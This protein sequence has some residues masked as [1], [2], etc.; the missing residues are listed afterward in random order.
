MSSRTIRI[1]K[2]LSDA[3]VEFTTKSVFSSFHGTMFMFPT[4]KDVKKAEKATG[5][6][7]QGRRGNYHFIVY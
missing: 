1:G 3:G 5:I 6:D 4:L 2:Q 7:V